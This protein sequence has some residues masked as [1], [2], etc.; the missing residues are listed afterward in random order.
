[1]E[2]QR[3]PL[4]ANFEDIALRHQKNFHAVVPFK[5]K[6]EIIIALDLT[7]QNKTLEPNTFSDTELFSAYIYN[8][9]ERNHAK[10]A[11]GGYGENR[12]VYSRSKLFDSNKP[13]EEPRTIHLGIDVWGVVGTPVLAFMGGMVHSTGFNNQF[14]DYGATLILLHQLDGLPFYTLYGHLSLQDIEKLV[15]GNYVSIGQ[16]IGHFGNTNENGYWPPHLHFQIILDIG[17]YRGDYP[18]VCKISEKVKWLSNS[19]DPETILQLTKFAI[20]SL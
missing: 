16:T 4:P 1:M 6:S 20:K 7:G 5:P 11:I 12:I 3:Q 13:D 14:G 19:P 18:G 9:L 8:I 2:I 10:F 15:P 17:M